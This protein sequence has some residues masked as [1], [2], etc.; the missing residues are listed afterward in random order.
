VSAG[1]TLRE[2]RALLVH[3]QPVLVYLI[4]IAAI[5][6][7]SDLAVTASRHRF[8]SFSE[9]SRLEFDGT[10][11]WRAVAALDDSSA[12]PRIVV[13]ASIVLAA[14][15]T[16]W[17]RA[18][19]IV[20]LGEGRY[21]VR[22]PA[23]TFARLALYFLCVGFLGLAF[24]GLLDNHQSLLGLGLLLATTPF[25]IYSDYAIVRDEIGVVQALQASARVFRR[26]L[27]ASL[28]VT[29]TLL[30]YLQLLVSAAF[31]SG[32]TDS[33]H[34]QPL[35]LVAWLLAGTLVMFLADA[36]LLTLYR[37]TPLS[38]GGSAAPPEASR[39][40]GASD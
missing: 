3:R 36:V 4:A 13:V 38:A 33:T 5:E 28:L 6:A 29:F 20:A 22:P 40:S 24:V 39:P 23:R 19:Y 8:D 15:A 16:G 21:T 10:I 7:A 1:Q 2:V 37:S 11:L 14:A 34:V 26:R 30:F 25:T 32:F 12:L 35:Y 17:L 27:A 9:F 31:E 18:C